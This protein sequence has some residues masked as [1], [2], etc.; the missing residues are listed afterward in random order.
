MVG[1]RAAG[2]ASTALHSRSPPPI[3][4]LILRKFV[5]MVIRRRESTTSTGP[6]QGQNRYEA[7]IFTTPGPYRRPD[8]ARGLPGPSPR[9]DITRRSR[10]RTLHLTRSIASVSIAGPSKRRNTAR[11]NAGVPPPVA[12]PR[13]ALKP[14][15][16]PL[17]V[18]HAPCVPAR[19]RRTT[20]DA[21]V[22]RRW[23]L[24]RVGVGRHHFFVFCISPSSHD[25][26]VALCSQSRAVL[27]RAR[28]RLRSRTSSG[29]RDR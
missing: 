12:G 5:E 8:R 28:P 3:L 17:R 1:I 16:T 2:Y 18:G 23:G 10:L 25:A 27:Q 14:P 26:R 13:F 22:A 24:A 6:S 4:K 19:H 15:Q 29:W 20:R 7:G 21:R 11:A 9:R